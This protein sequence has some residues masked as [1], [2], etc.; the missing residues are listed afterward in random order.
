MRFQ[1]NAKIFR[2]RLDAAPLAGIF[3]L[4]VIFMLLASL[5]YTPGIPI[6]ISGDA[7][8]KPAKVI[9]INKDGAI[10][11][12]NRT[13]PTNAMEQFRADLRT[14][15][16]HSTL[17]LKTLP[18]A[19][20]ELVEQIHDI[21]RMLELKFQTAGAGIELPVAQNFTGTTNP[22]VVVAINIAGQYFFE[23]QIISKPQLKT[24]L[25]AE[26]KQSRSPLTLV[27]LADKGV[28]FDSIVQLTE[29]AKQ[30]GIADALLQQ[31]PAAGKSFR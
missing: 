8:T 1:R 2:G 23:N 3:F 15:P 9:S 13:Y 30:A 10:V 7:A 11:F 26:A 20:R 16:P 24:Q 14:I 29:L 4:L 6:Q 22:T 18:N 25:A 28:E 27:V 17:V 31:R 21:A 12:D 19:P 5:V